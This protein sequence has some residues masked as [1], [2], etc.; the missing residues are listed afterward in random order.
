[1]LH[2]SPTSLAIRGLPALR[3]QV[4]A[5]R[6][7]LSPSVSGIT[8]QEDRELNDLKDEM[9][10][11]RTTLAE[12]T[13]RRV[14]ELKQDEVALTQQIAANKQT[15][16]EEKKRLSDIVQQAQTSSVTRIVPDRAALKRT[17]QTILSEEDKRVAAESPEQR[18]KRYRVDFPRLISPQERE[19]QREQKTSSASSKEKQPSAAASR[20]PRVT[21][22]VLG[23]R[24]VFPT[25]EPTTSK[26]VFVLQPAEPTTS[27][28][29]LQ[30]QQQQ[31]QQQQVQLQLPEQQTLSAST[32]VRAMDTTILFII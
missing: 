17:F 3:V 24:D 28:S 31:Q 21:A 19:S 5:K 9:K 18:I 20:R 14:N 12:S 7:T 10:R 8:T 2:C 11:L 26:D 1:M 22:G 29:G 6:P 13:A 23:E 4:E 25:L 32:D 15:I 16:D 27:A 30:Q